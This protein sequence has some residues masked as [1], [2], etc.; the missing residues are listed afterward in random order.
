VRNGEAEWG[1]AW[2]TGEGTT[3]KPRHLTGRFAQE[4]SPVAGSRP[5]AGNSHGAMDGDRTGVMALRVLATHQI[6]T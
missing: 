6:Q 5:G 1:L 3:P 4:S 2:P